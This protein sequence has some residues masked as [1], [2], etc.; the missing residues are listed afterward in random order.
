[1]ALLID[2]T[3][4]SRRLDGLDFRAWCEAQTIFISSEMGELSQLRESLAAVL[5]EMGF[6]VIYF[7]DFGGRDEDAETAYLDG[8]ARSDI[9][10]G[11][12]ADRYGR[13]LESGRSPTHEEYRAARSEGKRISVWV[14]ADG[15]DRQ[16]N[17]RDFVQELQT[18]HTTG[19]FSG[20]DDLTTRVTDRLAEIAAD[21]EAPWVKVGDAVFRA[22][23]IRDEGTR[24]EINAEVRDPSIARYLASL[25]PDAW[26]RVTQ[27]GITTGTATGEARV[28]EVVTE[29]RTNSR[30][31]VT[32]RGAVEWANGR[33]D[34]MRVGTSGYSAEDLAEL[35][36]R[37]ALVK[38]AL[39]AELE[40]M[41]FL[42][43]DGHPLD[44]LDR[45]RVTPAAYGPI[46][47]LLVNEYA[48]GGGLASHIDDWLVGPPVRDGRNLRLVYSEAPRYT[49]VQPGLRI[50]EGLRPAE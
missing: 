38:E 12:I 39:P 36:L 25:R 29:T 15:S 32:L 2:R 44:E 23:I 47:R 49:N 28:E 14:A 31:L 33:P 17:A 10:L 34:A 41:G 13:M 16:G 1:M 8:V 3:S 22:S 24:I 11:V 35:G 9:Y 50:I 19:N 20:I 27:V 45:A 6:T 21:D 4:T 37:R 46:A 26:N 48:L 42:V 18:F 43:P 40:R 30:Q 7:E 5:R